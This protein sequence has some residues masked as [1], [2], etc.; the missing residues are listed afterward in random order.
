M[1]TKNKNLVKVVVTMRHGYNVP[2][3]VNKKYKEKE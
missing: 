3:A 2:N 1:T